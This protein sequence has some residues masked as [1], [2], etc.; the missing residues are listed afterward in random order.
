[1]T[2]ASRATRMTVCIG[3]MMLCAAALAQ[4]LGDTR[5]YEAGRAAERPVIDGRLSDACWQEA[6]KTNQFAR[7]MKGPGAIQQ[8]FFQ[9]T[10]DDA[11]LYLGVTCVEPRAGNIKADVTNRDVSAVMADDALEIFIQPDPPKGE[12]FQLAANSLGTRYDGK[13]FEAGWNAT[14][15]A[16]GSVGEDA[17]YLE[18]AIAFESFAAQPAPGAVWGF[19]VCRDRNAGG[20]TEWSAWSD[21][22]GGFHTPERFG[23]RVFAGGTSGV[24]RSL[25]IECSTHARR[26]IR[27]E[28][29]VVTGLAEIESGADLLPAA[30]A[31]EVEPAVA[32]AREALAALRDFLAAD[33]PLDLEGWMAV[34]AQLEQSAEEMERTAWV[35]RFGRLLAD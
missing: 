25:I 11:H 16:A 24:N 9:V 7:I 1:M 26:S 29:L 17:W 13:A 35:I 22:L 14:W 21:T 31:A 2:R 28:E 10:Y 8:T 19:N 6:A 18:C 3:A 33:Q 23:R 4:E 12:Y 30:D 34:T 15:E 20:E 32:R 27:L 5:I